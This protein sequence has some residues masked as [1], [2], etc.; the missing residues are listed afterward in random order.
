M[1]DAAVAHEVQFAL[2]VG[3][4]GVWLAGGIVEVDVCDGL[5]LGE[6]R[7]VAV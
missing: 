2:V 3:F 7:E 4:D 5:R 1:G 6:E